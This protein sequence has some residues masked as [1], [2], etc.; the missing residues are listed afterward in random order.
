MNKSVQIVHTVDGERQM[1]EV[2]L[3]GHLD[4][5]VN[6]NEAVVNGVEYTGVTQVRLKE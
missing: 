3:E 2:P 6:V 5:L 1:T 4:V